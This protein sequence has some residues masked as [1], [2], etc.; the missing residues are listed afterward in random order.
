MKTFSITIE[1]SD[2]LFCA[3]SEN[4]DG[5]YG[6]GSTIEEAKKEALKGYELYLKENGKTCENI[7]IQW[8]YDVSSLLNYYK[9]IIS[10][11]G[12]E[13]LT[14]INQK[15][16]QHYLSGISKPRSLQKQKI[17]NGLKKLGQELVEL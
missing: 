1:R 3:F 11:A 8:K 12:I 13:R 9:G 2:D 16:L 6:C 5:A 17:V 4:F 7:T 14:G 15:Q 10:L